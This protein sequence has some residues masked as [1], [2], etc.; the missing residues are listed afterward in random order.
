MKKIILLFWMLALGSKSFAQANATA[1][2]S[3]TIIDL[4]EL[5]REAGYNA[6][7]KLS[8]ENKMRISDSMLL[9]QNGKRVM[10]QMAA[11]SYTNNYD[12][13]GKPLNP[14]VSLTEE[15]QRYGKMHGKVK[16]SLWDD[17]EYACSNIHFHHKTTP[18]KTNRVSRHISK[19]GLNWNN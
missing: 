7:S 11:F 12:K 5:V 10:K 4:D 17:L 15:Q 13:S 6:C 2:A 9:A 1:S 3:A 8:S 18:Q 14:I 16:L 19:N